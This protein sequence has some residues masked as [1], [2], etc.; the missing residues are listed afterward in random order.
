MI[1]KLEEAWVGCPFFH[2]L[3]CF[4]SIA[5]ARWYIVDYFS[6]YFQCRIETQIITSIKNAGL[7]KSTNQHLVYCLRG[8][9]IANEH[10]T[11]TEQL[12]GNNITELLLSFGS[13]W[14]ARRHFM[15]QYSGPCEALFK[16]QYSFVR[17]CRLTE[18]FHFIWWH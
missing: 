11:L 9:F 4:I 3:F 5:K 18:V 1:Q 7:F 6:M 14:I 17:Y 2:L 12:P 13:R 8:F 10:N 15:S 16:F